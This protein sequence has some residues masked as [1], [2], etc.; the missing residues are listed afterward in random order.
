MLVLNTTRVARLALTGL[1][2]LTVACHLGAM[3]HADD[4]P[5]QPRFKPVPS[6]VTG[7]AVTQP[8]TTFNPNALA[9][10]V[11]GPGQMPLS[12]VGAQMLI[13]G[14]PESSSSKNV[15]VEVSF[16][17]ENRTGK[18]VKFTA[19]VPYFVDVPGAPDNASTLTMP[20]L[21]GLN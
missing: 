14:P 6:A 15:R 1:A 17:L 20:S 21:K 18:D 5:Y 19:E 11:A 9:P 10:L 2:A 16:D 8:A 3:A 13:A 12:L 7:P 4:G